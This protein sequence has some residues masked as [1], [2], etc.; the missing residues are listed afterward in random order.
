VERC[1]DKCG[2]GMGTSVAG[3]GT[4]KHGET[5]REKKRPPRSLAWRS[6]GIAGTS[7]TP[8]RALSTALA[9]PIALLLSPLRDSEDSRLPGVLEGL[10]EGAFGYYLRLITSFG[11]GAVAS[12]LRF[13]RPAAPRPSYFLHGPVQKLAC[14]LLA[15]AWRYRGGRVLST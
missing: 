9:S 12:L 1:G 5:R 2:L 6:T 15:G 4:V 13:A 8:A 10:L 14:P 11:P 7:I 3:A